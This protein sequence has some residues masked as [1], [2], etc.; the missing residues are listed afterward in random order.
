MKTCK[1]CGHEIRKVRGVYLHRLQGPKYSGIVS[2]HPIFRLRCPCE[3][4]DGNTRSVRCNC[5]KPEPAT[6]QPRANRKAPSTQ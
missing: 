6:R 5:D 3:K 1:N 4:W 2:G